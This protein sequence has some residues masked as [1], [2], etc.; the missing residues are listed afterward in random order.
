MV[1]AF[2]KPDADLTRRLQVVL[3]DQ[4]VDFVN[5]LGS[6]NVAAED[7]IEHGDYL[8]SL[9]PRAQNLLLAA[10]RLLVEHGY[11][12]L[13]W[14]RIAKEAGEQKSTIAYYFGDKASLVS[15]L[16]RLLGQD[17]TTW[18]AEQCAALPPS[19]ER[20]EA[21][22]HAHLAMNKLPQ[23]LAF[24]DVLPHA[25]RSERL[26]A[27]VAELYTW[28]RDMNV[29]ALGLDQASENDADAR[30]LAWLFM[31]A[32]DG[33]LIQRALFPDAYDAGATY[34]K[35][36]EAIASLIKTADGAQPDLSSPAG[37]TA[38]RS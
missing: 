34:Q 20:I 32:I 15:A 33:I 25:I 18:M 13:T 11:E 7:G 5:R 17:A 29:R 4:S 31:A 3:S 37:S 27:Q 6:N 16:L 26:R 19:E 35:L 8:S 30:S 12:A 9:P 14:S 23:S 21:Y 38:A 1:R 28:Y 10:Q 22:L 2:R 36:E 24:F